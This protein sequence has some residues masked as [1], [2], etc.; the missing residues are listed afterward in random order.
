MRADETEK[1]WVSGLRECILPG[2]LSRAR[3]K[4]NY[5]GYI[6]QDEPRASKML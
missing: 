4:N 6:G 3:L 5:V 1:L 2:H